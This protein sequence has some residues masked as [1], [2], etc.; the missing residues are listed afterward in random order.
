VLNDSLEHEAHG[1]AD[2]VMRVSRAG[3][4]T[5]AS[6]EVSR[7]LQGEAAGPLAGFI[8]VPE[9][10]HQALR[11]SGQP[12]DLEKQGL[13]RAALPRRFQPSAHPPQ[14]GSGGVGSRNPGSRLY[15]RPVV[16]GLR[17]Y[18]PRTV[19]GRLLLARELTHTLQQNWGGPAKVIRRDPRHD[20][21]QAGEQ[22]RGFGYSQKKGWIFLQRPSGAGGQGITE[23]GFDGIAYNIFA[24]ELHILDNKALNADTARSATALT[25]N[26][27]TNMDDAIAAVRGIQNMEGCTKILGL[28]TCARPALAVGKPLPR[29][30]KLVVTGEGGN[31]GE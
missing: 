30:V 31:V 7:H 11:A 18:A 28:L 6:P 13:L 26:L 8:E 24:D 14:W 17:Q 25:T 21:D 2:R 1:V 4:T 22:A 15:G 3:A 29:R 27:L 23:P 20:R 5:P 16:F 12:L 9:T 10:L 19:A